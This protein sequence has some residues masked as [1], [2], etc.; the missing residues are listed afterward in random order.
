MSFLIIVL[1][2]FALYLYMQIPS[3][4]IYNKQERKDERK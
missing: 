1:I 2:L 4:L 3:I